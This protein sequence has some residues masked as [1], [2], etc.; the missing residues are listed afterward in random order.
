[1]VFNNQI[2]EMLKRPSGLSFDKAK[3]FEVLCAVYFIKKQTE[4]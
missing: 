3:D 1:M 2:I 4:L